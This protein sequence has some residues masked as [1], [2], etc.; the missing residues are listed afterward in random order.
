M[1]RLLYLD[2]L[3]VCLTVLVIFH[4]AG[5]AYGDGGDWAYTPS[6]PAEVMPWIWHFFS[7]NAAFFM[8]LSRHHH[9]FLRAHLAAADDSR[10][11]EGTI[12][13][14]IKK[15]KYEIITLENVQIIG[16]A[17]EIAFCKGQE[18]CPKFWG[19]YVERIIKPVFMEHKAPDAFQQAAI[20]NG[21]GEFGL[22]TCD[23]PNHNCATCWEANFGACSKNTFTYVIG[24]IYKGGGVPEGMQLFPIHS[25]K[26]LKMHFEGGMKAFQ[27]QYQMFYKE[28][29]PQHSEF[30]CP[31]NAMT[32]EWY[33]GTD[34]DSPNYQCG[35]MMPLE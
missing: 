31:N 3:K 15:M 27:E 25:G 35:V 7:V 26:W 2:N 24:G 20:D 11:K 5:Q 17:K 12:T 9:S 18:E 8:G 30:H 23:T 22:C 34:I 13:K 29:L 19:E 33:N 14:K 1:K 28:W 32:M 16:M 21:V 10:C 4:H 6:N